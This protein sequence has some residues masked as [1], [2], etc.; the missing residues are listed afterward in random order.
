MFTEFVI[1]GLKEK[2]YKI[3]K[4]HAF[5]CFLKKSES[6]KYYSRIYNSIIAMGTDF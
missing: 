5:F 4:V 1:G 6:K 3:K 2:N